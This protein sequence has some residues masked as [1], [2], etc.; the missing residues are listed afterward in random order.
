MTNWKDK[1]RVGER[2]KRLGQHVE[3]LR[4]RRGISLAAL[5][6]RVP[7]SVLTGPKVREIELGRRRVDIDD[8]YSL[9]E[10]LE[11]SIP[12]L[13]EGPMVIPYDAAA[14]A[15]YEQLS[16]LSETEQIQI[17]T[18]LE[19]E[20]RVAMTPLERQIEDLGLRLRE[21]EDRIGEDK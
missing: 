3:A 5:A 18:D 13:L 15:D 20:R 4:I 10:A 17:A 9:A 14:A 21:L 1:V 11:V 7:A 2:G 12:Y 6:S 19:S 16:R 8:L